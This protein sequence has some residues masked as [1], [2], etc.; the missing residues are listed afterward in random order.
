MWQ[1][2]S[3]RVVTEMILSVEPEEDS[4]ILGWGVA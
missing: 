3:L 4:A 2:K 1:D